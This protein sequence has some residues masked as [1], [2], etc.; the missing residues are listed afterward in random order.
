MIL[1]NQSRSCNAFTLVE[2]ECQKISW[3]SDVLLS[4]ELGKAFMQTIKNR[5]TI[6]K[7]FIEHRF[8][9]EF[10]LEPFLTTQMLRQSPRVIS[11]L[12]WRPS[13]L[14]MVGRRRKQ[15]SAASAFC[16]TDPRVFHVDHRDR[17]TFL[18]AVADELIQ[19]AEW[20]AR[21]A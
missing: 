8:L 16:R 14:Y 1:K 15:G 5:E 9:L 6:R 19:A 17:P 20:Y 21:E 18:V 3:H 11:S 2:L 4:D 12:R 10:Q 13:K 7:S